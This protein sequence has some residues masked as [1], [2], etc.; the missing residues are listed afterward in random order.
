M[1]SLILKYLSRP[2]L[3]PRKTLPAVESPDMFASGMVNG[4]VIGATLAIALLVLIVGAVRH[5]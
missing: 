1:M 2:R 5:G 4:M 3:K